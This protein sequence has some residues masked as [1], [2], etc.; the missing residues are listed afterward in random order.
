MLPTKVSICM[1]VLNHVEWMKESIQS[2]VGQTF[3]QWELLIVDDGS[4]EDVQ[5]AVASF[6]DTRIRCYRWDENRGVPHG[7]NFA[8]SMACGDYVCVLSAGE[9]IAPEKLEQQHEYLETH[10]DVDCVWGLPTM[11]GSSAIPVE[12]R[13]GERPGWMQMEMR[14]HNRSNE[15]WLKCLLNLEGVP[16]GGGSLMMRRSVMKDLG[17][18]DPKLTIFTDHDLYCSFFE[19]G[20]TGVVLPYVWALDKGSEEIAGSVRE[21]HQDKAAPEFAYVRAKHPMPTPKTTGRV[22]IGIPCY[23]HAKYL[24]DAV[25]SALAQ[26]HQDLEVMIL[27][28]G[29]TD[30]FDEVAAQ[31]TDPRVQILSFPQN[32]GIDAAA[33]QM[34]LRSTGDWYMT[35]AADDWIEPDTVEK[36][37]KE[38]E[39]DPWLEFVAT[40][41]DFFDVEKKPLERDHGFKNIPA[42]TNFATREEWLSNLRIG[43]SYFGVGLYRK[44]VLLDIGGWEE[45][46]KVIS[47]YQVYL[48]LLARGN[49]RVVEE[50]LTHTRVHESNRSIL[51]GEKAQELPWLYHEARKPFYR[52]LMKVVIATPFYEMKGFSPYIQSLIQTTRL[53]TAV[54]I[55]WAYLELSGDSYVHRARNTMCDLFLSDPDATDLFFIDSDMAWN[56]QAF[57]DMCMLPDPVVGGSYPVKNAWDAWTSIP[58][59]VVENGA[60]HFRGRDLGNGTALIEARVLAGGFLRIKRH[61]LESYKAHFPDLWYREASTDPKNPD[62]RFTQFF[63]S[64]SQD[65]QF[66]GEDHWFS[67]RLRDMGMQMMIYPN[68][69]ICHFG[70]KGWQGNYDTYLKDEKKKQDAQPTVN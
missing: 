36:C 63:A 35:L 47:D 52:Q 68:A 40:Q 69:T 58:D 50:K 15:A 66:Y 43:N 62:R 46:Y 64:Q 38:F 4:T 11:H 16:I 20:Y 41:T 18:F 5:G 25:N 30:N 55:D 45:K 1:S 22:T 54:G 59:V 13:F 6:N 51:R 28:D 17:Y 48:K 23:N 37:L 19:K 7:S 67:S 14:A 10:P 3:Q 49:I 33:N 57:V 2:V 53:L 31:F 32:M 26:T 24:P 39:K 9:T 65:H 70:V 12:Q 60:N 44:N 42:A 56:P 34:A 29:S 8:L 21:K 61:V 27:N